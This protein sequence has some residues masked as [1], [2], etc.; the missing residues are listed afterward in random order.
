VKNTFGSEYQ[1]VL[2]DS[3]GIEWH[4]ISATENGRELL[5]TFGNMNNAGNPVTLS[6]SPGTATGEV[7]L[8]ETDSIVFTL[9]GLIPYYVEPPVVTGLL[10]TSDWL[11][12][13]A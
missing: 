3:Y 4:A 13:D 10:N 12:V 5:L 9:T 11:E 2:T 6:Y 8:L 7:A 1:F